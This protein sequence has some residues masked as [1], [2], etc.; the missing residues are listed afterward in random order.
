MTG[1]QTTAREPA[2]KAAALLTG[3]FVA[4]LWVLEVFDAVTGNPLDSYGVRPRD[5]DGLVGVAVAPM[6][7]F[8]FDHLISNTVPVLVL[9]FLTLATGIG[10]GLLATAIIWVVGGLGV[11]VVA[12]PG[13]IHAGASI[14]IFGWIV[15]LVVRGLLN[16]RPTEILIGVAVFLLYSSALLG[17]L[18]GQPGVS[19]QGHL[20]GAIGGFVAAR[21][22]T[23]R[24]R[25]ESSVTY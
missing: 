21:V 20:F 9:G 12:Q 6:L 7:H 18:P 24:D 1:M 16:R 15:F 25:G 19:W 13:S 2:W 8:G 10:R 17:V 22:L 11:W 14:L 4:L 5:E 23:T 3:G